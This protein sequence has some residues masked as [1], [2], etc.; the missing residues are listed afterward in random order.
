MSGSNMLHQKNS[1]EILKFYIIN[2]NYDHLLL[3]DEPHVHHCCLCPTDIFIFIFRHF[4]STF[5]A[6]VSSSKVLDS[7]FNIYH[8]VKLIR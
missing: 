2:K 5:E 7:T 3:R 1:E 4:K 6:H 8:T